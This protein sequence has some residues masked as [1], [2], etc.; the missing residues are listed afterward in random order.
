MKSMKE[1]I[2][3]LSETIF[4]NQKRE[5]EIKIENIRLTDPDLWYY[6]GIVLLRDAIR[7]SL[8]TRFR[9]NKSFIITPKCEVDSV[10]IS[11][12]STFHPDCLVV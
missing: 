11:I 12:L 1:K 5:K 4:V 7:Y 6:V 8:L 3:K 10:Q 9:G 2:E